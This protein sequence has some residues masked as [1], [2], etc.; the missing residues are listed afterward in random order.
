MEPNRGVAKVPIITGIVVPLV[1]LIAVGIAVGIVLMM[2]CFHQRNKHQRN[3]RYKFSFLSSIAYTYRFK[4]AHT[5]LPTYYSFFL[6][7][8]A[9]R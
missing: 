8:F 3:I 6:S 1:V 2:K 4:F 7:F 5:Y 9:Y